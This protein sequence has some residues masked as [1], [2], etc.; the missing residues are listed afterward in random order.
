MKSEEQVQFDDLINKSSPFK[1]VPTDSV[2]TETN[3]SAEPPIN[4]L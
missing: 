4:E 3:L 1:A 2:M